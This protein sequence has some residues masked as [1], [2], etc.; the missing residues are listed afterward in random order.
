MQILDQD[1]RVSG[2]GKCTSLKYSNINYHRKKFYTTRVIFTTLHFLRN[3]QMG[4]ISKNFWHQQDILAWCNVTLQLSVPVCKLQRKWYFV[5]RSQVLHVNVPNL[6]F[7]TKVFAIT[8]LISL[9]MDK[10]Q[11]K[12]RNLGRV[13]N[14]RL[15]HACICCAIAYITKNLT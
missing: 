13:F 15:G 10:L 5:S 12:G 9:G 8:C 14:S 2:S 3:F 11:L 6:T 7:L 1:G 4:T